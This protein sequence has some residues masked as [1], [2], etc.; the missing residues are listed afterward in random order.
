MNESIYTIPI[1][2]IFESR[3]GCPICSMYRL[4]EQRSVEYIMGAAMMEPDVREQ[5]NRLGFCS[6]HYSQMLNQKNRLAMALT[7]E[8]HLAKIKKEILN[9]KT[10]IVKSSKVKKT[11]KLLNT[12][13]VCEHVDEAF[14]ARLNNMFDLYADEEEFRQLFSEQ[15][16]F[17]LPHYHLICSLAGEKLNKEHAKKLIKDAGA[18][19]AAYI[20]ELSADVSKFCKMFDYRNSGP[21]AD[22]G[23]SKNSVER[24]VEFLTSF[25]SK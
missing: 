21:D 17:C 2:E 10:G 6:K 15:E 8:S 24:A 23:T 9:G 19:N 4:L 11:Y 16:M 12:C 13:Y 22:W 25:K 14:S 18:V 1:S 3:D 5:T 7:M 20:N